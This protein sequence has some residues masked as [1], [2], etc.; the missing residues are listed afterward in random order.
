ME[1]VFNSKRH[2]IFSMNKKKFGIHPRLGLLLLTMFFILH[3]PLVHAQWK[4]GGQLGLNW[5]K[6]TE[7]KGHIF[8][9]Q[10]FLMGPHGGAVIVHDF[11]TRTAVQAELLYQQLGFK[12]PVYQIVASGAGEKHNLVNRSHYI[13]LPLL[14]KVRPTEEEFHF[15]TG[16]QVSYLIHNSTHLKHT[17]GIT[18][19]AQKPWDL[20]LVMGADYHFKTGIYVDA[21]YQFGLTHCMKVNDMYNRSIQLSV[22]YLFS[23][24][25]MDRVTR[26]LRRL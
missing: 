9:E 16:P 4:I 22:G 2:Y 23:L 13:S 21:R 25:L 10:K 26:T 18:R 6:N 20:S 7:G 24:D 1:R 5:S 3:A 14:F 17:P 11:G 15:L 8:N 12:I 19:W